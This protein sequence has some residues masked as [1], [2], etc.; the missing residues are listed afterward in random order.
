MRRSSARPVAQILD[1]YPLSRCVLSH[2]SRIGVS[3]SDAPRRLIRVLYRADRSCGHPSAEFI[4]VTVVIEAIGLSSELRRALKTTDVRRGA[5]ARANYA[6]TF[7]IGCPAPLA[8][9]GAGFE[10][11]QRLSSNRRR[12]PR[13]W[14]GFSRSPSLAI[15]IECLVR[16]TERGHTRRLRRE[17][18]RVNRRRPGDHGILVPLETPPKPR[19]RLRLPP[20]A[21][22]LE[23]TV[24]RNR[25]PRAL[26]QAALEQ[27]SFGPIQIRVAYAS[28]SS[29]EFIRT[30]VPTSACDRLFDSGHRA[31]IS[32]Q[33][34]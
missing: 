15:T 31:A 12:L 13:P 30:F 18:V 17:L 16:M 2:P 11:D 27:G 34:L 9:P 24:S 26:A 25:Q 19:Y 28:E 32:V 14:V 6:T 3:A 5:A 22:E 1:A 20:L 21:G 29:G 7:P 33:P 4:P 10:K 23:V 8:D